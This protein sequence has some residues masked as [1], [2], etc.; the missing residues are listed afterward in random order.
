[1]GSHPE[2]EIVAHPTITA[3]AASRSFIRA[4]TPSTAI[5]LTQTPSVYNRLRLRWEFAQRSNSV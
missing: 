4:L 3:I 1:M 2:A 5:P